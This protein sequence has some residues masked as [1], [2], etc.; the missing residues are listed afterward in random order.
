MKLLSRLNPFRPSAAKAMSPVYDQRGAWTTIYESFTG[1]WQ[2]DVK[3][4][5][6]LAYSHYAQ[7]ACI[8]LIAADISKLRVKLIG[9]AESGIWQETSNGAYDGVLRKPNDFQTRNQFWANW[10]TSKL[11]HGNAY[12]LKQRDGGGTVRKLY[13]LDPRLVKVLVSTDGAIFYQLSA[14]NISGIESAVTVPA[15]EIIHDRFNCF[16]HPLVGMPPIFAS[17]IASMQGINIQKF[18]ARFFENDARPG[19]LLTVPGPL[20]EEQAK[21]VLASWRE[22]YSGANSGKVALLTNGTTFN[23][24][25]MKSVDAQMIEQLKLTAEIVCSTY[26]VPPYK[27]G[28][29]AMPASANVEAMQIQYYNDCLQSLIEDAETC[30]DEGLG[31]NNKTGVEF[32]IDGLWRMDTATKHKALAD[33]IRGGFVT[34]NEA[35]FVTGR[36]PLEGGDTVYLQHQDYSIAAIAKR[37]ASDDPFGTAKPEASEEPE[38]LEEDDESDTPAADP[39]K[40]A[41]YS[42][43]QLR[44]YINE[45]EAA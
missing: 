39:V 18:S 25:T 19:G 42:A 26:H 8:S 11:M 12:V 32:D 38:A 33:G 5:R 35:R 13:V 40:D 17:G 3:V 21:A 4:D 31:L 6:D 15:R 24:M 37:D 27:I 44:K 14:D 1:A 22:S 16:F 2:K 28:A 23:A 30:L 9:L 10:I 29:A 7:F 41:G 43:N 45:L 36:P 20:G 34:P